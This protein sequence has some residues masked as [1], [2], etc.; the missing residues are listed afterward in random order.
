MKKRVKYF[1]GHYDDCDEVILSCLGQEGIRYSLWTD[2]LGS[3]LYTFLDGGAHREDMR[4]HERMH[5]VWSLHDSGYEHMENSIVYLDEFSSARV[6]F[7]QASTV[8]TAQTCGYVA[9][10][11]RL[12]ARRR[13]RHGPSFDRFVGVDL[14]IPTTQQRVLRDSRTEAYLMAV[15]APVCAPLGPM[16]HLS[17]AVSPEAVMRRMDVA[18]AVAD[19]R[20]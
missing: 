8:E 5:V 19:L 16:S 15:V 18:G 9:Q 6:L 4:W 2:T 7:R 20:R 14:V 17:W 12:V 13:M 10:A 11:R 3:E 1:E